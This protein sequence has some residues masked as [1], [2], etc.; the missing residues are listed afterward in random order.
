MTETKKDPILELKAFKATRGLMCGFTPFLTALLAFAVIGP[1]ALSPR[2]LVGGR[3]TLLIAAY[4]IGL[5]HPLY[6]ALSKW[7]L[8][9]EIKRLEAGQEPRPL[10]W[11][12]LRRIPILL[13][14]ITLLLGQ[15]AQMLWEKPI[16]AAPLPI[17][18][19]ESPT[20]SKLIVPMDPFVVR[21][22]ELNEAS[23]TQT[24]KLTMFE[25][26]SL[27]S[28][29]FDG[30]KKEGVKDHTLSS[31]RSIYQDICSLGIGAD[32]LYLTHWSDDLV[33][34]VAKKGQVLSVFEGTG[35]KEQ[36]AVD[37][38]QSLFYKIDK[39]AQAPLDQ[40]TPTTLK[41]GRPA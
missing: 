22:Y 11:A 37:Y 35:F 36:E 41:K 15:G 21:Q 1:F 38:V 34:I 25:M 3:T 19:L 20:E 16:S 17:R 13:M 40:S 12:K 27:T 6:D 24:L 7:A 28:F 14:M 5:L 30:L 18:C 32:E 8:T 29:V 9:E 10:S 2:W 26:R 31:E 39:E 4:A 33:R 23:K